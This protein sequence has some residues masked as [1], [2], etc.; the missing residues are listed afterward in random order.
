M[1]HDP[2]DDIQSQQLGNF[3]PD[4]ERGADNNNAFDFGS[5]SYYQKQ[6]EGM[7]Y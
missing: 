6:F 2:Y 1:S 4:N 5:G 7:N 3:L